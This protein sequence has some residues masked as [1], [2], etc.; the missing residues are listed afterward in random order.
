MVY[1]WTPEIFTTDGKSLLFSLSGGRGS[2]S[3]RSVVRGTACG[4]ASALSRVYAPLPPFL[5]KPSSYFSFSGGM[6]APLVGG[7]LLML[8]PA[9]PVYASIIVFVV[10]GLSALLLKEDSAPGAKGQGALVH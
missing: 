4:I 10:A 3:V 9:F 6:I 1:R 2:D 8:N 5:L 7:V